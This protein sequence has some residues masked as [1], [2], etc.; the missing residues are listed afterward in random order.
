MKSPL[1][2]TVAFRSRE[3]IHR[4]MKM[5]FC[6]ALPPTGTTITDF[7]PRGCGARAENLTIS[8]SGCPSK[9]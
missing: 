5:L 8:H 6:D 7:G 9:R 2:V 3:G 4:V 1:I